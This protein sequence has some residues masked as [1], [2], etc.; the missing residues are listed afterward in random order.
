MLQVD[1]WSKAAE[2]ERAIGIVAD[3]ER[4]VVLNSLRDVWI[5]LGNKPSA[6]SAPNK[7]S[8]ISTIAQIHTQLMSGCKNA[9]H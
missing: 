9:M 2:C 8:Q 4:R 1:P 7:V 6:L 3:P 5:T